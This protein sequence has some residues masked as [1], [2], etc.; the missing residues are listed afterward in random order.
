MG[1]TEFPQ[2]SQNWRNLNL[3][4]NSPTEDWEKGI[5]FFEDRINDRFLLSVDNLLS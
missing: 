2:I 5:K 1:Y 4:I 3:G